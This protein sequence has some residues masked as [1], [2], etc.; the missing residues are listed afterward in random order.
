MLNTT[1]R[2][3]KLLSEKTILRNL[4]FLTITGVLFIPGLFHS[5]AV[6]LVPL[7]APIKCI[8]STGPN[9][10]CEDD[11]VD[12]RAVLQADGICCECDVQPTVF[13][14]LSAENQ[15]PKITNVNSVAFRGNTGDKGI[16][17]DATVRVGINGV[18][19]Y[20]VFQHDYC[21]GD[22]NVG[23]E[24]IERPNPCPS[25]TP[26]PTPRPVSCTERCHPYQNFLGYQ[27]S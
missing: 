27:Y 11:K 10:L 17:G 2:L 18:L 7:I 25:P 23:H 22:S 15:C 13:G 5:E 6:P 4:I 12:T 8:S 9:S 20:R 24:I 16:E 19:V 1:R 3:T 26:T 14:Y 21:N